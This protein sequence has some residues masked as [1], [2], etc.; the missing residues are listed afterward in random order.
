MAHFVAKILHIRPNEIL[1]E[2]CVPELIVSYGIY[3]NEISKSNFEQWKQL[4]FKS[5]N[6]QERPEEY[7]VKFLGYDNEEE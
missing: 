3:A 5:R 6:G 1:D 2:W 7:A 4:D